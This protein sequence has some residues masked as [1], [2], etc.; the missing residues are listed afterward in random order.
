MRNLKKFSITELFVASGKKI[1]F[2]GTAILENEDL[3]AIENS[4]PLS[5]D[6][7][8]VKKPIFGL[9]ML[10]VDTSDT[11]EEPIP[12]I[13]FASASTPEDFMRGAD[14]EHRAIQ[15]AEKMLEKIDV[16]PLWAKRN[17]GS[18]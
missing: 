8:G 15:V 9:V 17:G 6:L 3:L 18:D 11:T 16:K 14:V 5:K 4:F 12:Y 7:S 2:T 10:S 13:Y 1:V